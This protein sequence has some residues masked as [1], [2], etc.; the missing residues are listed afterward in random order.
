MRLK[1]TIYRDAASGVTLLVVPVGTE[2]EASEDGSYG[3]VPETDGGIEVG[4]NPRILMMTEKAFTRAY[5]QRK[6][7]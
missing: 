4:T 7:N 1:I 2:V 6:V 5:S 3:E